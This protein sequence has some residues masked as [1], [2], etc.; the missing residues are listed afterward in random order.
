MHN[1]FLFVPYRAYFVHIAF[2][3]KCH[4]RRS[5]QGHVCA[6]E[7]FYDT[8]KAWCK[9]FPRPSFWHENTSAFSSVC[10]Y[11]CIINLSSDFHSHSVFFLIFIYARTFIHRLTG[12]RL[13]KITNVLPDKLR[14]EI[15]ILMN[16]LERNMMRKVCPVRNPTFCRRR[17]GENVQLSTSGESEKSNNCGI[18][19]GAR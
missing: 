12:I 8:S 19:Y 2:S 16:F 5:N 15:S 6:N 10:T 1:S 13:C 9:Y 17:R 7:L 14:L 3:C 18:N 11:V 4:S